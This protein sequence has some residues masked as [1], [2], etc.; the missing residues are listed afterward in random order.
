MTNPMR[1]ATTIFTFG[2]GREITRRHWPV[3]RAHT[4][5]LLLVSPYDDPCVLPDTDMVAHEVSNKYGLPCLRR[6]L[7]GMKSALRYAADYY[8]FIEYDGFMLDRP[9]PRLDVQ[10]NVFHQPRMR[11]QADFFPH[12]P[13]IFPHDKLQEFVA[14]ATLDPLEDG[15][16]DRWLAAQ[17]TR[18][19]QPVHDLQDSGEGFSRNTIYTPEDVEAL[20]QSVTNGAYAL[21]GIKSPQ[22]L[23]DVLRLA[24]QEDLAS[25]WRGADGDKMSGAGS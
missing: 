10:A 19:G 11:Y 20:R 9:R 12:F 25:G 2:G 18:L 3:W 21:H 5:E 17:L 15:F 22:L 13:W 24:G 6:Q 4:D 16:V 7:F 14:Q 8:V 23:A 1:V